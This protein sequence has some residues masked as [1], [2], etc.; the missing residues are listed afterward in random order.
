MDTAVCKTM[1]LDCE[2]T[3]LHTQRRFLTPHLQ[4]FDNIQ[5][6]GEI[7]NELFFLNATLI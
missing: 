1:F 6:K 7:Y 3:L 2:F 4:S 5:T